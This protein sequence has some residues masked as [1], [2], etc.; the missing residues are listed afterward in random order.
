MVQGEALRTNGSWP[1]KTDSAIDYDYLR[2]ILKIAD[3]NGWDINALNLV[4][5]DV[6][7]NPVTSLSRKE[8][9]E[10][11]RQVRNVLKRY[12]SVLTPPVPPELEHSIRRK[13][14]E[15]WLP[16]EAEAI[17]KVETWR[18]QIRRIKPDLLHELHR[19]LQA[20]S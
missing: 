13:E 7:E 15:V 20:W 4:P 8:F 16:F 2:E 5:K 18:K 6:P 14:K 9:Q 19:L 17:R 1:R 10:R 3:K 12:G 11:N